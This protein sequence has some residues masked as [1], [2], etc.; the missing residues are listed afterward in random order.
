MAMASKQWR[1]LLAAI[2]LSVPAAFAGAG[3]V[4]CRHYRM[5]K[6]MP[7]GTITAIEPAGRYVWFGGWALRPG[8]E[9][10][11][12]RFDKQ[13]QKW[14]LFL[15]SEGVTADEINSI[16]AD[17]GKLWIGTN[18]DWLWNRGLHLYDPETQTTRR[19]RKEDGLPYWRVRDVAVLDDGVWAATMGGVARYDRRSGEW[20]SWSVETGDLAS[21]FTICIHAEKRTVWLGTFAGLE[22]FDRATRRWHAYKAG[23]SIF[24]T[25]VT[26]I[27]AD[28]DAVW[29]LSAPQVVTF[30]RATRQ[31]RRWQIADPAVS[32]S[33]L[34]NIEVTDDAVFLGS[35]AGLHV[36]DKQTRTWR[37]Y[38]SRDGLLDDIV[39]TLAADDDYVW[40]TAPLGRGI[41]RLDRHTGTWRHFH[42]RE[43]APSN[44]IYSLVSD[45]AS[46]FVGTLGCGL[47]KY[48]IRRSRWTNLNLVLQH[49]D[50]KFTY[51]G[52]KSTIK[53]SDIRQ[54]LLHDGVVWMATNHG[55]CRHDP[56]GDADIDVLSDES[57]PM[58]CLAWLDG[59]LL[60]GGQKHGLRTYNPATREWH[61]TGRALGLG[62]RIESIAAHTGIAW[63]A[64]GRRVLRYSPADAE[65]TQLPALPNVRIRSL[66]VN[67]G[68]LW[69]GTSS[70]LWR[71]D[72]AHDSLAQVEPALL[73]SPVVL[74]IAATRGRIWIGTVAGL[75]SCRPDA[76]D[77]QTFTK[78]DVLSG[79]VVSAVE[80][81]ARYLW[82]GTL[83]GGFTRLTGVGEWQEQQ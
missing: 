18:S 19:F 78:D 43:G 65:L 64:D 37:T 60:C 50:H 11:V 80:G 14:R 33:N 1:A 45:G 22:V 31:Y 71:Y 6:L 24:P 7:A 26:D 27:D 59:K 58:L 35:D 83:G 56:A 49:D 72:I 46:L 53:Y 47:W 61:N 74:T 51:R 34:R 21:N 12:A 8:E 38:T 23:E 68:T 4:L 17:G 63:I 39:Y 57:F 54:M 10:G 82:V 30:D 9:H 75:A 16:K 3:E 29:F 15:E 5:E 44:H 55:L 77:W 70:G 25:A 41:S 40:C 36:W 2:S 73:P 79:N 42:Y 52:E 32:R 81:D 69:I 76:T 13:T 66:L 20:G 48:D 62:K 67:D 28:R